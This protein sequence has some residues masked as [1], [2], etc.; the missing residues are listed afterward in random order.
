MER[1]QV[2]SSSPSIRTH[3]L[4]SRFVLS[5]VFRRATCLYLMLAQPKV[6]PVEGQAFVGDSLS[7]LIRVERLQVKSSLPSIRTHKLASRFLLSPFSDV[8]HACILC[9]LSRKS[10]QLKDKPSSAILFQI[11][12]EWNDWQVRSSSP[13]IRTHKL[14]SRFPTKPVFRCAT[15]LY[16][17]LAQPK[18]T[19]VEGQAFVGDS[20]SDLIR[21]ERLQVRSSS[22]S[23]R[24]HTHTHTHTTTTTTTTTT[25]EANPPL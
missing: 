6:T 16:L 9:W 4:A 8:Q 22:P 19:P 20:L 5:P 17:M 3:K 23:V 13:S 14:A 2:R 24:A 7:D 12:S 25:K 1:L 21:V 18:V 10:P 15:C 11:S